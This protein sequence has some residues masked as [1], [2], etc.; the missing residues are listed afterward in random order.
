MVNNFNFY[1]SG[2]DAVTYMGDFIQYL[3]IGKW[4]EIKNIILASPHPQDKVVIHKHF[5]DFRSVNMVGGDPREHSG[6][7]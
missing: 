3:G 7:V 1:F 4:F 5:R 2:A 6:S